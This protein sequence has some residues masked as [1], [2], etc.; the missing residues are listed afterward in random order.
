MEVV[1]P[2]PSSDDDDW[3]DEEMALSFSTVKISGCKKVTFSDYVAVFEIP[4]EERVY[5]YSLLD[6]E[7]FK[8]RIEQIHVILKPVLFKHRIKQI[9]FIL[10]PVLYNKYNLYMSYKHNYN[11]I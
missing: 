6:M 8:R 9:H 5:D 3:D 11:K 7:R 1:R 4:S 10:K 2:T